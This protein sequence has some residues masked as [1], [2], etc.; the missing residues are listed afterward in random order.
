MMWSRASTVAATAIACAFVLAAS[1][2]CDDGTDNG[3]SGDGTPGVERL[4]DG[5]SL[6][7]IDRLPGGT[8]VATET[9]TLLTLFCE[10]ETVIVRTSAETLTATMPCDR[11]LPASVLEGFI[12]TEVAISYDESRL[13]IAT[14]S[15]GSLE[16]PANEPVIGAPD[17]T[18]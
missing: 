7:S 12:G 14:E 18:P 5:E 13:I 15:A 9:R 3:V 8:A 2:A 4:T 17:A 11:M 10:G 1:A 16:L 6:G